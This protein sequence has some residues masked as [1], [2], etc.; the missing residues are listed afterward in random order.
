MVVYWLCD[1]CVLVGYY[2]CALP[3]VHGDLHSRDG[4]QADSHGSVLLLP[5]GLEHVW[6]HHCLSQ[7]HGAGPVQRRGT[8]CPALL[9][10]GNVTVTQTFHLIWYHFIYLFP[11]LYIW[12]VWLVI[13]SLNN[14][15][16]YLTQSTTTTKMLHQ[17]NDSLLMIC[18]RV[19]NFKLSMYLHLLP[20]QW[21][22]LLCITMIE[23][24]YQ[25]DLESGGHILV[26]SLQLRATWKWIR[27]VSNTRTLI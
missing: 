12:F 7:P 25:C 16:Y 23:S 26:E 8:V 14:C 4:V 11:L 3:G 22:N 20:P 1:G 13:I 17:N 2:L 10:T 15:I 19:R 27:Y 6:W 5:A 18:L 21:R 9:Q 24:W